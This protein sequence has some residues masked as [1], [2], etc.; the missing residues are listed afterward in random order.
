MSTAIPDRAASSARRTRRQA[1]DDGFTL[2]EVLVSLALIGTVMTSLAP[3]LVRSLAVVADQRSRQVA[4]QLAGDATERV[5]A[6][7]AR[8]ALAGR[9]LSASEAAWNTAPA[10]VRPYLDTMKLTYDPLL[11]AHSTAGANA[12]LP[13]T[14]RVVPINGVPYS[15]SWYLGTCVQPARSGGTCHHPDTPDPVRFLRVVAAVTWPDRTCPDGTCVYV[16]ATLLSDAPEPVFDFTRPPPEV[17]AVDRFDYAATPIPPLQ[18]S[19]ANGNWPLVWDFQGL[20]PKLTFSPTTGLVTGTPDDTGKDQVYTVAAKVTDRRGYTDTVTFNW[21]IWTAPVLT[22]PGN[23]T[24]WTGS[25]VSLPIGVQHGVGPMTWTATGLPQGLT[26]DPATGVISGTPTIPTWGAPSSVK[27]TV[28]DKGGR[29][30]EVTF[31]WTVRWFSLPPRT[32][33]IRDYAHFTF[34]I[35]PGGKAPFTWRIVDYPGEQDGITIDPKT[36]V[37]DGRVWYTNRYITTIYVKDA[38]GN[39]ISTEIVWN[40]IPSSSNDLSITAPKPA[41]PDQTSK[42]GQP[43]NLTTTYTGGS[44]SGGTWS[45]QGLPPGLSITQQGFFKGV[46]TGT[47]TTPGTYRVTLKISDSTWKWA[48]VMFDWTVQ[49]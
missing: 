38:T 40:T 47:P 26:I 8:A 11:P 1:D 16:T 14:P 45:A 42:V 22:N 17:S 35:P 37:V 46:I 29:I 28:T 9:S 49:P 7:T 18:L 5:R 4:V 30:S 10:D 6:R 20:P 48:I 23:Q 31:N 3:F 39:E 33:F 32:D 12:G 43:V 41:N 19:T 36:G 15:Q 27:V 44:G 2:V 21:T 13:T 25:A 34:P 24:S